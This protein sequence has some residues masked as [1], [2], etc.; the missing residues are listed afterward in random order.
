MLQNPGLARITYLDVNR[1]TL[2]RLGCEESN[3][4][5]TPIAMSPEAYLHSKASKAVSRVPLP[6]C[7]GVLRLRW[8]HFLMEAEVDPQLCANLRA[9]VFWAAQQRAKQQHLG[10]SQKSYR[11]VRTHLSGNEE[12]APL[13]LTKREQRIANAILAHYSP[14]SRTPHGV[15]WTTAVSL[16][17]H[18]NLCPSQTYSSA[19]AVDTKLKVVPLGPILRKDAMLNAVR[20]MDRVAKSAGWHVCIPEET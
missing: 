8:L 14:N 18:V 15:F 12:S 9:S 16:F 1:P 6:P 11:E 2:K 13:A 4:E 3:K 20:M 10:W 5:T 19:A 17:V 7:R